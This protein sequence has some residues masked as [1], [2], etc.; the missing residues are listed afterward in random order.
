MTA[1]LYLK[2]LTQTTPE[3]PCRAP[4]LQD[5]Q[6]SREPKHPD[7]EPPVH[8]HEGSLHN[9]GYCRPLFAPLAF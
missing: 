1:S 3:Q 7:G 5:G 8:L 2:L 9:T 4:S 6:H